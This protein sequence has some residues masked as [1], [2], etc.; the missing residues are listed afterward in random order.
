[1]ADIKWSARQIREQI[2]AAESVAQAR[3]DWQYVNHTLDGLDLTVPVYRRLL[4]EQGFKCAIHGDLEGLPEAFGLPQRKGFW[5]RLDVDHNPFTRERRGIICNFCNRVHG[6]FDHYPL[7]IAAHQA[8]HA[9][10][11]G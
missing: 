1:M 11:M 4:E 10:Y 8:Y 6:L 3:R 2:R 9:R 7:L 5:G